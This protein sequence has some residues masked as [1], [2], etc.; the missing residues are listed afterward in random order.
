MVELHWG[1]DGHAESRIITEVVA[2]F[3]PGAAHYLDQPFILI[4]PSRLSTN[5]FRTTS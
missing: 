5:P 1:A 4:E 2:I 3:R